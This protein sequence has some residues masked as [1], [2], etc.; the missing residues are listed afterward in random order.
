MLNEVIDKSDIIL[1]VLDARDPMSC[2]NNEIENK[3]AGKNKKLILILNKC[4]LVPIDIVQQ[5]VSYLR[6]E[7]PTIIF[8]ANT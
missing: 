4:D 3:I 8:K 1:E 2:R 5:W 6:R 7:Y